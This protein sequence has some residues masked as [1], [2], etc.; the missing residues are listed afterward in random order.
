MSSPVSAGMDESIEDDVEMNAYEED[1]TVSHSTP[2][3]KKKS[4][5]VVTGR[6]ISL[7]MLLSDGIIEAG[8][9]CLSMDYLGKKFAG[10]LLPDGKIRWQD[11]KQIF[12]SPSAWAIY[13]KKVVNP[14]KKSGCGW[15]SVKYK[16]QKLDQFKS[17]WF[18]KQHPEL[19]FQIPS[20]VTS[21]PSN[22]S[23]T[24]NNSTKHNREDKVCTVE[25]RENK[26][27]KHCDNDKKQTEQQRSVRQEQQQQQQ[28]QP[29]EQ[30]RSPRQEQTN[31]QH[32]QRSP[33]YEQNG[34]SNEARNMPVKR[35]RGRPRKDG[36]TPRQHGTEGG[37]GRKRRLMDDIKLKGSVKSESKDREVVSY[38][39]LDKRTPECRDPQTLVQC[40]DF[41]SLGKNQPFSVSIKTNCLMLMDF[42][43]HLTRSEVVGYLGG[44]WDPN[45]QHLQIL[46]AFP[47]RCRL[48]DRD[49]AL[50]VE[51]EIRQR[52]DSHGLILVGWYHSH[53]SCQ[54]HP[55]LRDLDCQLEY[56]MKLKASGSPAVGP[57]LGA[58][59][60]PYDNQQPKKESSLRAYWV[61]APDEVRFKNCTPMHIEYKC[62]VDTYLSQ[63]I[64]NEMKWL[65]DYYKGSPD[66]VRFSDMWHQS[67]TFMDKL[68]GS[69][70]KKLPK[71]QTDGR[72]LEFLHQLLL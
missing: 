37:T 39:S 60:A 71:D 3:P 72:F 33:K 65:S 43:C 23:I 14:A 49:T 53:P 36:S 48:G 10:D 69:L 44:V 34:Y 58:I 25:D 22:H 61:M 52:M 26:E 2:T 15:S 20:P 5:E 38:S 12:N 41:S 64:L 18:R 35:P 8:E 30:Y 13:C 7:A 63:D 68:K 70:A 11:T 45:T 50:I 57:C 16:G 67:N 56:Q 27:N 21:S 66:M 59:I 19:D 62:Q 17:V 9:G 24:D 31:L 46:Q 4:R 1:E 55:S 42:H 47:C 29:H 32:A 51:E 6:G 28:Q 54:A 40:A